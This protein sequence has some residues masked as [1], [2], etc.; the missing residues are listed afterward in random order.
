MEKELLIQRYFSNS[1]TQE[2]KAFFDDLIQ[3]DKEFKNQ[4]DFELDLQKVIGESH[5]TELKSKLK[6]FEKEVTTS[7][8]STKSIKT[9]RKWLV[10]ASILILIGF[11][12]LQFSNPNLNTLYDENFQVYP[13]AEVSIT[14]GEEAE[15]LERKAFIAYETEDYE[16]ALQ[17]F[18]EMPEQLYIDFYKAQCHL[19][20]EQYSKAIELLNLNISNKAKYIPES[21]WYMSMA[22][23][24]MGDRENAK[25]SLMYLVAHFDYRKE[26]AK[27]L[28]S[29]LD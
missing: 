2:E 15:S 23:L 22:Y 21:Y 11:G 12:Y 13:N 25:N 5:R 10:A 14:R 7:S 4:F 29:R 6:G 9:Y 28:I 18:S 17:L 16:Q 27:E 20:L 3:N 8:K 1:L 24:K 26:R 19:K